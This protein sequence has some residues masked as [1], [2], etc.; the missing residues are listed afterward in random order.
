MMPARFT[1]PTHPRNPYNTCNMLYHTVCHHVY[2]HC[3]IRYY[4]TH[5]EYNTLKD[6]SVRLIAIQAVRHVRFR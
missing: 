3:T 4:T 5:I 1:R 2:L 6:Y